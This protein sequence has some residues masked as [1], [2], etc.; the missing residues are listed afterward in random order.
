MLP[1]FA[2]DVSTQGVTREG[3]VQMISTF[4]MGK[5]SEVFYIQYLSTVHKANLDTIILSVKI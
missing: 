2:T 3:M 4:H 1:S 5:G